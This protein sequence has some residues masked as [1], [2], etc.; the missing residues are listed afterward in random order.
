MATQYNLHFYINLMEKIRLEI[1]NNNFELWAKD[2]LN[3]YE[4]N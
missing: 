4:K 2:F 3:K 1:K